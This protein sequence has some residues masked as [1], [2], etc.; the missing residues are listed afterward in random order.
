MGMDGAQERTK[1]TAKAKASSTKKGKKQ[2]RKGQQAKGTEQDDTEQG[3]AT[4]DEEDWETWANSAEG[5]RWI[6]EKAKKQQAKGG[7]GSKGGKG[8]GPTPHIYNDVPRMICRSY[9]ATGSCPRR[10]EHGVCPYSHFTEDQIASGIAL[11]KSLS[12]LTG[13]G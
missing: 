8:K 7:K 13:A 5:R 4:D 11:T 2:K 6:A 3:W 10:R 1:K 9:W 12:L